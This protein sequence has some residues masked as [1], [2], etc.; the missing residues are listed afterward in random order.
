MI[1]RRVIAHFRKQEWTA[2]FLDFIIVVVGVFVGLQVSNWNEAREGRVRAH[3][4]LQRI[5][6]DL[7]ADIATYTDRLAFWAKVADYGAKGLD[8]A[9]TGEAR[10]AS[11]WDLLLAFFQSS[12]VAE[13]YTTQTTYDELTSAGEIGLIAD[14][15]LRN[16]LAQ[17]YSLGINPAMA[18]RPPYRQHVRGV[19]PLGV[20]NYIWKN[21]YTSD[22]KARQMMLDCA[23][24]L[25]EAQAARI[26]DQIRTDAALM[27]ELRYWMS[28][29]QVAAQVGNDRLGN[30]TVMRAA[31]DA[32]LGKDAGGK[33]R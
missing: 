26:V 31:V 33:S 29:M 8:Y 2:I 20:Q 7:D 4:Y 5:G 13:F 19:I 10:G 14:T 30:A 18:E 11:Q 1:L 23:S 21:C 17:Y 27:A 12:Q 28:T 6:A 32:A 3:D 16:D 25:D 9:E 15:G 24:P 22:I